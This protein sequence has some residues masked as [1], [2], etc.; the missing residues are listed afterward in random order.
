MLVLGYTQEWKTLQ[1]FG[2]GRLLRH[3]SSVIDILHC[4]LEALS[5][6]DYRAHCFRTID[7]PFLDKQQGLVMRI[8]I[9]LQS[10]PEDETKPDRYIFP[11]LKLNP[12]VA[13]QRGHPA[14]VVDLL[15]AASV[16]HLCDWCPNF[17]PTNFKKLE[18]DAP[19]GF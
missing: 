2:N 4:Y 14:A 9:P 3:A 12:D 7:D 6:D 19:D 1:I 16:K 15:Q 13:F 5:C 10:L 17:H 11:C 18:D 8:T